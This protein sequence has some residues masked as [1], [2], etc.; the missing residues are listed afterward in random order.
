MY[1]VSLGV[2]LLDNARSIRDI[3]VPCNRHLTYLGRYLDSVLLR[4]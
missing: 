4:T 3:Q 1:M 2:N